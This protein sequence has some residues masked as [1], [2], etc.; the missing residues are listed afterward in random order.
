MTHPGATYS[1]PELLRLMP[2]LSYEAAEA[3]AVFMNRHGI[4]LL[5]AGSDTLPQRLSGIADAPN[6]LFVLGNAD[7]EADHIVAIVGTR[8]ATADGIGF[9][10]NLVKGIAEAD[11]SAVIVSGLAYGIDVTAHLAALEYG[12][13]TVAVVAHGLDTL[14]PAAHRNI[15][16]RIVNSGGA[17]V[18]E[19]T[20]GTPARRSNFLE[21]NRIV[22]ALSDITVV[23]QSG[24]R[25]GSLAT[26]RLAAKYGR[27]VTAA[28]SR[29]DDTL[30]QGS[31]HLIATRQAELICNAQDLC[32]LMHW[33]SP[34]K[35]EMPRLDF[36]T[37]E[38]SP[39][40]AAVIELLRK[41]P[42]ARTNDIVRI[43]K[44]P[45]GELAALLT[46]MEMDDLIDIL[47]GSGF[48]LKL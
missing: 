3:E 10:D 34:Q 18:S 11:P 32:Q 28:P 2:A 42:D 31:N 48:R 38:I 41:Q 43:L 22:A 24:F 17:I 33:Y 8:K 45:A 15:A 26:A 29:W 13:P 23:A 9:T 5:S 4:S 12:L 39:R 35:P 36:G 6:H 25:G 37:P 21:R 46:E 40:A 47:P 19:Y 16:Q 1:A 27:R 20:S 30:G 7:L 14:Y 44:I